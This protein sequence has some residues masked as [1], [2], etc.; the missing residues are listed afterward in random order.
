MPTLR[1]RGA[2]QVEVL[3][4]VTP[5]SVVI[6]I[7]TTVKASRLAWSCTPDTSSQ[8]GAQ[9]STW[10]ALTPP[11]GQQPGFMSQL[12][13]CSVLTEDYCGKC[14]SDPGASCATN[15]VCVITGTVYLEDVFFKSYSFCQHHLLRD[16]MQLSDTEHASRCNYTP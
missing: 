5:C 2:I 1:I 6:C 8:C 15:N 9:I 16:I 13:F 12:Q 7:F 10:T 3:W 4:I 11:L 14:G